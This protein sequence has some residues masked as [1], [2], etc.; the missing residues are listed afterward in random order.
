LHF[1]DKFLILIADPKPQPV[2]AS[3]ASSDILFHPSI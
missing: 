2:H 3:S 1:P